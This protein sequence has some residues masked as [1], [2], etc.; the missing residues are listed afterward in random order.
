MNRNQWTDG[1]KQLKGASKKHW[2][3]WSG[4]ILLET[5][6]ELLGVF[7]QQYG[8]LKARELRENRQDRP[9]VPMD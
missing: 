3:K 4:D 5:M 9:H 2:G 6:G 7:Q 8:H 1:L